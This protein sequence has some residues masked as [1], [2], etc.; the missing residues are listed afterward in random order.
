M[1]QERDPVI[2]DENDEQLVRTDE[3]Y[4]TESIA[5][6]RDCGY[7]GAALC[8]DVTQAPQRYFRAIKDI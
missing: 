1:E 3:A 7:E 8:W 5:A 6:I 4:I 2:Y